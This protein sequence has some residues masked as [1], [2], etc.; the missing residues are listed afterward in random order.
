MIYPLFF[1]KH[2]PEEAHGMDF[3][4][5]LQADVMAWITGNLDELVKEWK[6]WHP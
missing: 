6:K 4:R 2:V 1:I 3:Y 5:G